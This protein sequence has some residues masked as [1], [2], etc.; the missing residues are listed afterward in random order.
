MRQTTTILLALLVAAPALGPALGAPNPPPPEKLEA[1]KRLDFLV[2]KWEGSGWHQAGPG[3]RATFRSRE[4]VRRDLGGMVLIVRGV[5]EAEAPDSGEPV[6]VHDAMAVLSP[7]REG[8]GY[9]FDSWLANGR[10][11]HFDAK[12]LDPG[13]LRWTIPS[14]RG[15]IRYTIRISNDGQWHEIGEIDIDGEWHQFFEMNL[16]RQD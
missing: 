3:E 9:R 4:T 15:E 16:S 8:E 7:A 1:M 10:G 5:H 2:G 11:G 12:L 6:V 13:V 14:P